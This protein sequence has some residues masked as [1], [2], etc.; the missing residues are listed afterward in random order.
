MDRA[1]SVSFILWL[2]ALILLPPCLFWRI[3]NELFISCLT[4]SYNLPGLI[5]DLFLSAKVGGRVGSRAQCRLQSEIIVTRVEGGESAYKLLQW[6]ECNHSQRASNSHSHGQSFHN[7][8]ELWDAAAD[9]KALSRLQ[10]LLSR[11]IQHCLWDG[12]TGYSQVFT[13]TPPPPPPPHLHHPH[14]QE[15]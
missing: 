2:N 3:N 8:R 10:Q 6:E 13:P 9:I 1:V 7:E 4:H 11:L 15:I 14:N 12:M 5:T